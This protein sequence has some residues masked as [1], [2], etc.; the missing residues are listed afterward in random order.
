MYTN[1]YCF[2]GRLKVCQPKAGFRFSVDAV[3]LGRWVRHKKRGRVLDLGCGCGIMALMLAYLYPDMRVTGIEIQ[4]A[5]AETA[6]HNV[7]LNGLDNLRIIEGDVRDCDP[8]ALGAPFDMIVCNPPFFKPGAGRINLH[9]GA[10]Q[11]RHEINLD[12]PQLAETSRRLLTNK[13]RL[14]VIYPAERLGEA[15]AVFAAAGLM[16]KRL[17]CIHSREGDAAC[18]VLLESCFQ[19]RHGLKVAPPLYIY[20]NDADY[21][22]EVTAMYRI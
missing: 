4:K 6:R 20:K 22:D 9:A 10:A 1:D 14:Y 11:A 8:V 3:L 16:P 7:G 5:L 2:E 13:G 18:L 15:L 17:R 12:L 19:G 21:T